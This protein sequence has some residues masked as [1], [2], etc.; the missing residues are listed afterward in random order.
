MVHFDQS[1]AKAG[2]FDLAAEMDEEINAKE[3]IG[4]FTAHALYYI[5]IGHFCIPCGNIIGI[6]CC[7]TVPNESYVV[8]G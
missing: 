2:L 3:I 5:K 8:L 1:H 7:G 4:N 6:R